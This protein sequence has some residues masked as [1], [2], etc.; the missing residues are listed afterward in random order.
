MSWKRLWFAAIVVL[1]VGGALRT[2]VVAVDGGGEVRV[3]RA[4]ELL[5]MKVLSMTEQR[6]KDRID[7]VNLIA[8]NPDLDLGAV[9]ANLRLVA[10][11]GY[12]RGQDLAGKLEDLLGGGPAGA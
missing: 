4:E 6:L 1:V 8:F 2:T 3:A 11:R 9:R 10:G 5:A 7:A 12:D